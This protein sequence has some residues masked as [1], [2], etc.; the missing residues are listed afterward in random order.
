MALADTVNERTAGRRPNART[1]EFGI[2][3]KKGSLYV[4]G[5]ESADLVHGSRCHAR[6]RFARDAFPGT[7]IAYR[8]RVIGAIFA[9]ETEVKHAAQRK[10]AGIAQQDSMRGARTPSMLP[11]TDRTMPAR[12]H[13]DHE[14]MHPSSVDI[15]EASEAHLLS[16]TPAVVLISRF[17]NC[18]RNSPAEHQSGSCYSKHRVSAHRTSPEQ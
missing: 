10:Q 15:A 2:P 11:R 1:G 12:R 3:G 7:L 13:A 5:P 6:Q 17:P 8:S 4:H 16:I 9:S 18:W 14:T